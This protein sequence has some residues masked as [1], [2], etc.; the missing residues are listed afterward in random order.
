M[1]SKT[2]EPNPAKKGKRM[3]YV[4][5]HT[6]IAIILL[7]FASLDASAVQFSQL[8]A[9]G[10]SY[11]DPGNFASI[12][13]TV[14]RPAP[15]T[16]GV[17]P[18]SYY[19][20]GRFTNGPVW[21]ERVANRLGLAAA[22]ALQGGTNYAFGGAKA[23]P[24]ADPPGSA[25]PPTE[26]NPP[27]LR[28]QAHQLLSQW[29]GAVP[30]DALYVILGGNN[31][32]LGDALPIAGG[33]GDPSQVLTDAADHIAQ[34]MGD[35]ASAGAVNFLVLNL[36]DL[37]LTPDILFGLGPAP[38]STA[39][40]VTMAFNDELGA[41]L[42]GVENNHAIKLIRFDTFGFFDSVVSNPTAFGFTDTIVPSAINPVVAANFGLSVPDPDEAVWWDGVHPTA[43]LH[44]ALGDAV[45][46]VVTVPEPL[47]ASMGL[48][49]L[50]VLGF[51]TCRRRWD[52]I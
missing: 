17:D 26:A 32:V 15:Y 45:I 42:D 31:D 16:P 4:I 29:G 49:G 33:G 39:R 41:A 22:P 40:S 28:D 30:S 21:V 37:G 52:A 5:R 6:F 47:T 34:M 14:P 2:R 23:G 46:R 36:S 10:D 50:A 43:A 9:F 51:G 3:F 13:G 7:S 25:F 38:S 19:D 1:K 24:L 12:P 18:P 20:G 11:S 48:V 27:S 8:F 35:L 44:Q